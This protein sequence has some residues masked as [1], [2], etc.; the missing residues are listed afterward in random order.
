MKQLSR[1]LAATD[2]SA[3]ARHAVERAFHLSASA[4]SELYI[5]H[6]IE[7]DTRLDN[8]HWKQLSAFGRKVQFQLNPL[9]VV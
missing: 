8:Y 5:L 2:L 9:L 7:L 3:P 1:I 4:N 6:A